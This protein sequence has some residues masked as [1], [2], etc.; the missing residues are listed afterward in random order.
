[1]LPNVEAHLKNLNAAVHNQDRCILV[2]SEIATDMSKWSAAT[3]QVMDSTKLQEGLLKHGDKADPS[4]PCQAARM[5]FGS[6]L[7]CPR[8]L[9]NDASLSHSGTLLTFQVVG[10]QR[11]R[12]AAV[13]PRLPGTRSPE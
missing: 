3:L 7:S 13:R 5:K 10:Q 4:R 8:C 11:P 12:T 6:T 1:M 2:C 9:Q